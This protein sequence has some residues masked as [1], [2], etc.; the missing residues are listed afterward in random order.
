MPQHTKPSDFRRMVLNFLASEVRTHAAEE[1]EGINEVE[2]IE[3]IAQTFGRLNSRGFWP[4]DRDYP[5]I[6]IGVSGTKQDPSF[7]IRWFTAN[8][9][10]RLWLEKAFPGCVFQAQPTPEESNE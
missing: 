8:E 3:V 9:D 5:K 1:L 4:F 10:M 7:S 6:R 2:L